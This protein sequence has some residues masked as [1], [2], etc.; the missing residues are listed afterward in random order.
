[1]DKKKLI[2]YASLALVGLILACIL[3]VGL[4]DGI[5]PW[6]GVTA[7][8]RVILPRREIQTTETTAAATTESDLPDENNLE[9]T[10]L[11]EGLTL[12]TTAP[13]GTGETTT[14]G[15]GGGYM[16]GGFDDQPSTETA[17]TETAS[18]Y[19]DP[20]ADANISGSVIPGW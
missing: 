9:V 13:T 17:T 12:P 10:V 1:M 2:L 14:P 20:N 7:Y 15:E 11:V 8:R 16:D 4:V 18:P 6:D 19:T 5:W 3:I